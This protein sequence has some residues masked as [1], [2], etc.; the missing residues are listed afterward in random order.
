M[1]DR[2]DLATLHVKDVS[3]E[4][5]GT[6]KIEFRFQAGGIVIGDHEV[7]LTVLGEF[8]SLYWS[9]RIL[10]LVIINFV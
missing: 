4:D 10:L 9:P 7:N 3:S 6:Y 1:V 2:S 5:G 8:E